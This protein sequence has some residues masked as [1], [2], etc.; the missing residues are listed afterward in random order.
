MAWWQGQIQELSYLKMNLLWFYVGY[1]STPLAE[2]KAI[3]E[4]AARYNITV[5]PQL[6]MPGH[7]G[8]LLVERSEHQLP[9]RSQ[10]LDLS[11]PAAY[12]FARQLVAPLLAEFSTPHW[13]LGSDEY[14][15]GSGYAAYPQL[16]AYARQRFGPQAVP[17][18]VHYGFVNDLNQTVRAAQKTM[19]V[20]NDGIYTTAT[21]PI[22]RNVVI[23]HWLQTAELKNAARL[24]AE[25][26]KL[27]NSNLDFLY[28]DPGKPV[29]PQR[30]YD[31]FRPGVFQGPNNTIPDD[32]PAL[33]GAKLHLW[34]GLDVSE[35]EQSDGLMKPLRSLAQ[36]L[37][38]SPKPATSYS[39]FE[40]IIT[41]VG[42]P[43]GFPVLRHWIDPADGQTTVWTGYRIRVQFSG[44]VVPSSIRITVG[45]TTGAVSYDAATRTAT[46]TPDQPWQHDR[47]YQVSLTAADSAGNR[48]DP[49]HTWS[50]R[51]AKAAT[52]SYPRSLFTEDEGPANA[53]AIDA[54][55]LELGMRFRVDRDGVVLGV[56]YYKGRHNR[57]AHFGTLWRGDGTRLATARFVSESVAGWQEVRFATP[58]RVSAGTTYVVSYSAPGNIY[59]YNYDYFG[60]A[61]HNGML[62]AFQ[63]GDGGRNGVFATST[64]TFPA[65]N[66]DRAMNYWVDA[67]YLP[68]TRTIWDTTDL[69][70][71][72][73]TEGQPLELGLRFQPLVPG[74]AV[75]VR[76]YKAVGD[77][78]THVGRLWSSTGTLLASATFTGER[79]YGWHEAAFAGPVQ[80][81]PGAT[82]VVSYNTPNGIYGATG[83]A[84]QTA[85]NVG[86]LAAPAGGNGVFRVGQ[87]VFPTESFGA[88]NYFA[89]TVFDPD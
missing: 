19:R 34:P 41:T 16:G 62:H 40:P 76:F 85:R 54:T 66:G 88:T 45:G 61:K 87:G 31:V 7:M 30:L 59:A 75:G 2:M 25:G 18:D 42:R 65:L 55:P 49:A 28:D 67:L 33:V 27:A 72:R 53:H 47:L 14:L 22:D 20:W 81:T 36:V 10:S 80:L 6:N 64:L 60:V 52:N 5:V 3:A 71:A 86:V 83:G 44:D 84:L 17:P 89:D 9:G 12:D 35:H 46:F 26:Y 70:A 13:H 23:E 48:I 57:G 58:V 50:F 79:E 56:R 78:G 73:Y 37:W 1:D 29:N 21:V 43:P 11:E 51:T 4:Y 24:A 74:R 38:G 82:Y 32:S 69:P 8:R 63:D 39:G 15:L 77:T 68:D